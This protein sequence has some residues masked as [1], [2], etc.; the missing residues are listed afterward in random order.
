MSW[1]KKPSNDTDSCYG[2]DANRNFDFGWMK[3]GASR[4]ECSDFYAGPYEVSEPEVKLLSNFLLDTDKN[5]R[6]FISLNG[7]GQK[8]SFS[9][10][11]MTQEHNDDVRNIAFAGLRNMKTPKIGLSKYRIDAIKKKS[12]T[13]DAF[14]AHQANI[15][16]SY[17]LEARDDPTHGFFVPATSIEE[18]AREMFDIITGMAQNIV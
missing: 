17:A 9:T 14:A 6:M 15:K 5:I 10:E 7:F 13:V 12:G 18:N 3:K 16:Y 11:A 2:V 1:F 4:D 8:I